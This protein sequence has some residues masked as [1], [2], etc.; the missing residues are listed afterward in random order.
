VGAEPSIDSSSTEPLSPISRR[1]TVGE[2]FERVREVGES[3]T[4]GIDLLVD[5]LFA[6]LRLSLDLDPQR[7]VPDDVTWTDLDYASN[8]T[9][10][11]SS[12]RGD[13]MSGGSMTST[14]SSATTASA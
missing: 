4:E 5:D 14:G 8:S 3:L 11:S 2:R 6:H 1:I 13:S 9:A 7:V 12:P 10:P